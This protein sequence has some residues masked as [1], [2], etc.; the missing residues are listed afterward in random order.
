MVL[1]LSVGFFNSP[2]GAEPLVFDLNCILEW[3]GPQ[4]DE[5]YDG[6]TISDI[7]GPTSSF[8]DITFTLVPKGGGILNDRVQI[9]VDLIDDFQKDTDKPLKVLAIYFNY[10]DGTFQNNAFQVVDDSI[11]VSENGLTADGYTAGSFDLAIPSNG[12]LDWEPYS[13][14][15]FLDGTDLSPS[16]FNFKDSTPPLGKYFAA[17]HIGNFDSDFGGA[18]SIWIGACDDGGGGQNLVPEPA[19]MLLLGLG[20]FG[21][22]AIRRKKFMK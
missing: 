9:E 12:N 17:V 20:I 6:K 18:D 16:D 21:F 13:N 22:G 4:G 7:F 10:N 5:F 8:G 1:M 2:A 3:H 19:T 11:G 14:T 15:I